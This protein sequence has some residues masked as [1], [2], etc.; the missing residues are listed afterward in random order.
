MKYMDEIGRLLE[1]RGVDY[2]YYTNG[3]FL[4]NNSLLYFAK[5]YDIPRERIILPQSTRELVETIYGF[6][7]IAAIRMHSSI[8]SYCPRGSVRQSRL[9]RQDTVFL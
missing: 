8:I 5:E 9:E 3:S 7:S 1:E 2:Y 6:S 4:D